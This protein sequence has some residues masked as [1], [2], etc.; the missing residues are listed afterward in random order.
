MNNAHHTKVLAHNIRIMLRRHLIRIMLRRHLIRIML[1]R[2][3]GL[4]TK[5]TS[6]QVSLTADG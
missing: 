2:H 4:Q 3:L 1:R 5:K 6:R